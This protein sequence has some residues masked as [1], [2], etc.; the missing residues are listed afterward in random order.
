M[1][2]YSQHNCYLE[3]I[4]N[5]SLNVCGCV[6]F[7]LPRDDD[8]PI[9][10]VTNVICYTNIE[11]ELWEHAGSEYSSIHA[12]NCLPACTSTSYDAEI[13]EG[14]FE[15]YEYLQALD[16][17]VGTYEGYQKSFL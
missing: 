10:G 5:Y 4:A 8:T 17:P 11:N 1:Q 14:K 2:T 12:C 6:K 16:E 15:F 7:S 13:S 3:C 9:C